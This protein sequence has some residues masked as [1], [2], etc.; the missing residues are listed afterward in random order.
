MSSMPLG[1]NLLH[2]LGQLQ[3]GKW[4]KGN[5]RFLAFL[6]LLLTFKVRLSTNKWTEAEMQAWFW[7]SPSLNNSEQCS[8]CHWGTGLLKSLHA[9]ESLERN[10]PSGT[11]L[12]QHLQATES[13]REQRV[14]IC[15]TRRQYHNQ[16]TGVSSTHYPG[17][18]KES[19]AVVY[20]HLSP[21]D[22][23]NFQPDLRSITL[24]LTFVLKLYQASASSGH[25]LIQ[26]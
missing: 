20:E 22:D 5:I 12:F 4:I 16:K 8:I 13:P 21:K 10:V 19:L 25:L 6:S 15:K 17:Q 3:V 11:R 1:S 14:A 7:S 9:T 23:S 24:G 2:F 18:L 26:I